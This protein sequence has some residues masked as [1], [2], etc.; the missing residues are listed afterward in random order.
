MNFSFSNG[1]RTSLIF[2]LFLLSSSILAKTVTDIPHLQAAV[3]IDGNITEAVWK[4]ATRFDI[5]YEV[6][7]GYN[8]PS[9]YKTQAYVFENGESLFLAFD[10]RDP[11]PEQIRAFYRDRDKIIDDDQ[12][13]L[14]I[15]PTNQRRFSFLFSVNPLGSQSDG[16]LNDLNGDYNP[17]WDGIWQ[18]AGKRTSQGYQVEMEIPFRNLRINSGDE[19]KEMAFN[20]RRIVPRSSRMEI[21][22]T[23]DN[24]DINCLLCQYD[25][26]RGFREIN[27]GN[28]IQVIPSVVLKDEKKRDVSTPGNPWNN[29]SNATASLDFKWGINDN[30]SLN[31]TINP[32]FSQVEA[33]AVKLSNNRNFA[34]FF[35]EKRTFFLEGE[36]LFTTPVSLIYT[37]VLAEPDW[38]MKLTAENEN[39]SW[40]I[41]A[42]NDIQTT[43]LTIDS[44]GS[45]FVTLNSKSKNLVARY[46]Q[47]I[48]KDLHIG[49]FI[50][51]RTADNYSN[52][53][54]SF[55]S[56][57]FISETQSVIAQVMHSESEYPQQLVTDPANNIN[58]A[59]DKPKIDDNAYHISYEYE[60]EE[61]NNEL[62]I[63]QFG[64]DFRA[65]M[66]FLEQVDVNKKAL[67]I[68]R[69]WYFENSGWSVVSALADSSI[70]HTIAG[71][72]LDRDNSI[73]VDAQGP[74][75]SSYIINV[76]AR[77][78]LFDGQLFDQNYITADLGVK[79]VAGLNFGIYFK[80]G[81]DIDFEN[82][83]SGKVVNISPFINW[84]VNEHLLVSLV[85]NYEQLKVNGSK[86]FHINQDDL[87][88]KWQ[89]NNRT[90]LR[91]TTQYEKLV[92][93]TSLYTFAV[94]QKE[95]FL[96][97]ELLYSYKINPRTLVFA[98]I[99]TGSVRP[100]S[101]TP[102]KRNTEDFFLKFSYAFRN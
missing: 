91:L 96:N 90:F 53:V 4:K 56:K 40:G 20:L 68:E 51:Q 45:E 71:K 73:G 35:D 5:K 18:S 42:A 70:S 100:D 92:R 29:K 93:N 8:S 76:H 59:I 25:S 84:N 89:F 80:A 31:T 99:N 54:I 58:F 34:L 67:S 74:M 88:L 49:T 55:D 15:D 12:V 24:R 101:M 60:T 52:Q 32:D 43:F 75:Q 46:D 33:D 97:L 77:T 94:E 17:K 65:D 69:I 82:T 98:G 102:L 6:F 28:H 22:N 7:P 61:W 14:I 26:V 9:I 41:F 2:G 37:R 64:K 44:Q 30:L 27:S 62:S 19:L 21:A 1:F 48:N 79:P 83:R 36:D 95:E 86:L 85:H 38:G 78:Q 57:Y 3:D 23:K 47:S 72:L 81:D 39:S 11:H 87:R 13:R 10:A 66:G 16:S 50:S 63:T